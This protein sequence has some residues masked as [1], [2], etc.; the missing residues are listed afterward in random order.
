M[1]VLTYH[2]KYPH[3]IAYKM[4]WVVPIYTK[5]VIDKSAV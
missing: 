5:T 3:N 1:D 4:T 2:G